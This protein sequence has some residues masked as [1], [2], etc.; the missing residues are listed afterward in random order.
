MPT[1]ASTISGIV[2][3]CAEREVEVFIV[4]DQRRNLLKAVHAIPDSDVEVI[5]AQA[6]R[7]KEPRGRRRQRH[8]NLKRKITL[9]RKPDTWFKGKPEIAS[10][11][12]RPSTWKQSYRFVIRRTPI[13]D[14]DD[15][16]LSLH[17]GLLKYSYY[18][19][20]TNS[21]RSAA[22][23]LRIAQGRG[24]Q[25]NLIKDFKHGLGCRTC[26]PACWRPTKRTF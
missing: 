2:K 14:K 17:D 10:I 13:I 25:E 12:F 7:A 1:A 6:H 19:V 21:M 22:A 3:I 9:A 16:Q 26:R 15:K 23:V 4:A 11:E 24:D 5:R 18:I 8:E 20:V